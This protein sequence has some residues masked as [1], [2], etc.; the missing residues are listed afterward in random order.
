MLMNTKN[1]TAG[2][3]DYSAPSCESLCLRTEGNFLTSGD[4]IYQIPDIIE[5]D[6]VWNL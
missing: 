6:I 5:S 4:D 3:R 2:R 1:K